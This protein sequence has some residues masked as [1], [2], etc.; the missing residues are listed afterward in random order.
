M[1]INPDSADTLIPDGAKLRFRLRQD[2][3]GARG[4]TWNSIFRVANWSPSGTA[5]K[6]DIIEFTWN[7]ELEKWVESFVNNDV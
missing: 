2:S 3:T 4:V 7:S 1:T 6:I 5:N